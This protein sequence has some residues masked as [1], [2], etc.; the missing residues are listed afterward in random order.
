MNAME[1]L[2]AQME[3]AGRNFVYNLKFIPDDKLDWK[4]AETAPSA[5]EIVNHMADSLSRVRTRIT[6]GEYEPNIILATNREEAQALIHEEIG[7]YAQMLRATS[8]EELEQTVTFPWGEFSKA[9]LAEMMSIEVS[10]HHG[11]IAYIQM[12]L[13]DTE[14]HF[15]EMGN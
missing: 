15:E 3:W 4:P 8:N 7:L 1:A 11:Q 5:L 10:H 14:S 6:G 12:L 13:G 2:A 9:K